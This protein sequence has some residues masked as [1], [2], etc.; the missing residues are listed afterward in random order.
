MTIAHVS[1]DPLVNAPHAEPSVKPPWLTHRRALAIVSVAMG[2]ILLGNA[3]WLHLDSAPPAW[4]AARYLINSLEAFDL[5]RQPSLASLQEMYFIRNTVRPSIGLVLPTAPFYGLFG[6]SEDGAT[7]WTQGLYLAV[8]VFSVYGIGRR[9]FDVRVGL[10]AA[11]LIGLNPEMIRLSRIYWPELAAAAVASLTVYLLIRSDFLQRRG[12]VALA[13]VVLG[14]GMMQRPIFPLVFLAGPLAFVFIGSLI[15]GAKAG[16]ETI[17]QRLLRR[18]LPG[19]LLFSLPVLV[20]DAPFYV[21]YSQQMMNYILGFQESGTFAPVENSTSLQS[22]LWYAVNLYA[23]VS[24]VFHLLFLAGIVV[25][26]A[27]LIRRRVAA[28]SAIV[29]AW[30]V[31]PYLAL[32]LTASKGFSYISALYPAL[33]LLLAFAVLFVFQRS[34]VAQLVAGTALVALAVLTYWQVSWGQPLPQT[35]ADRL[36]MYASRPSQESWPLDA[37]IRKIDRLN[38]AQQS[39]TVGVVAAVP[40]FAEP[41]LAYYA[42]RDA[43][44]LTPI[45]WTDPIP[46]LLEADFVVVKTDNVAVSPPRTLED[47]NATLVSTLLQQK[48]S[49]FYTTHQYAGRYALPDGSYAIIYQ[50]TAEPSAQQTQ[51]IIDELAAAATAIG[52]EVIAPAEIDRTVLRSQV[53]LGK[54][55]YAEGRYDEARPV[56]EQ[57]VY[58]NPTIA[59][60]QQGLGRTLFALGDCDGA[61]EHQ[62]QAVQLL[63]INGTY[64]VFGDML[65]ECQRVDQAIAAYQQAIELDPAEVRT[66]FVLAQAYMAKGQ[67]EDAI[68]EFNRTLELDSSQQFA[69][70]TESFL[71]QL[72]GDGS[73]AAS[74]SGQQAQAAA[75]AA[76]V[77][78]VALRSQVE[79]AKQL[80]AAGQY[81]EARSLFQQVVDTEPTIADAQQGLARTLFVLGD[82]AG[83]MEHQGAAV[84]LLSINGTYTVFGDILLECGRVDEAIVAYQQGIELDPDV[85]RTH[86]VLAQAFMAKGRTEDAIRAFN[87]TIELDSA[88]EFTDRA[89]LFLQQL[90]SQ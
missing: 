20:I 89:Q 12:F 22:L 81:E 87:R 16:G 15:A 70:R 52:Q 38:S 78:R 5:A 13:G 29:L 55:L 24:W 79:Q 3:L 49:A 67:D 21:K 2:L 10:L 60:A 63:S 77:D 28:S 75:P 61:I 68:R 66:H 73:P 4:D 43:P 6:V 74:A 35:V 53:E 30:V 37:V 27:A 76:Q 44:Q 18:F 11:L 85:V 25:Y 47:K 45:R 17:S 46:T 57:V 8:V 33:A 41:P 59:D 65:L 86:F 72:A 90:Q 83:A 42:R 48:D 32:S 7:L 34:R 56:F 71:Q 9:L 51:K 36:A 69:A 62:G 58:A 14:V 26:T 88:G 64:T 50:R 80:H 39:A 82:C 84:Q 40:A 31:V 1:A 23:S 54:Q 19:L